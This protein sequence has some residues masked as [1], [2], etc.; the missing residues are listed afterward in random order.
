MVQLNFLS[1]NV[2]FNNVVGKIEDVAQKVGGVVGGGTGGS[3]DKQQ[4]QRERKKGGGATHL[5]NIFAVPLDA[6]KH[7][8]IIGASSNETKT[9]KHTDNETQ[10][11]TDHLKDHYLFESLQPHEMKT[12]IS[13]FELYEIPS[14]T[15][16]SSSGDKDFV[17]IE[18]GESVTDETAYFYLIYEGNCYYEVNNEVVG[19]VAKPGDCFGELALLYNCPRAATVKA[20]TT[21]TDGTAVKL[22]RIHQTSF[23]RIL[24]NEN[25]SPDK[26]K[27]HLLEELQLVRT[28]LSKKQIQQLAASM[29][30]KKFAE[31]EM[32]ASK[33]TILQELTIIERGQVRIM[34]IETGTLNQSGAT[35]DYQD[36]ILSDG[37]CYGERVLESG[38][39]LMYDI[40]AETDGLA[41]TIDK[42]TFLAAFR[43]A[44]TTTTGSSKTKTVG[45]MTAYE[46]AVMHS[47]DA[48]KL[49]GIK[50]LNETIPGNKTRV[51]SFLASQIINEEYPINWEIC[52]EGRTITIP[53]FYFVR[54]GKVRVT[55]KKAG[56]DDIIE[57]DFY[58]GDDQ[59]MFDTK[60][61][62]VAS[63]TATIV[64]E[65]TILGILK[66]ESLRKIMNTKKMGSST[67]VDDSSVVFLFDSLKV[68]PTSSK[69]LSLNDLDRLT[70]LGSGTFGQVWLVT[71][72]GTDGT[73]HSYALKI[74]SK[75]ELIKNGQATGVIHE[76][77][78]MKQLNH[79]FVG[80]LVASFHDDAYV[81]MLMPLI[82]GGELYIVMHAHK[83]HIMHEKHALFY[84]AAITEGLTYMH[85]R[86][87][88]YR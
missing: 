84:I 54:K 32:L 29:K 61:D 64:E 9:Y 86:G 24:Q 75:Y 14:S 33:G 8:V 53:A 11:L 82:Q 51:L 5:R 78:I 67:N 4:Q 20:V 19:E 80:G 26:N 3:I 2:L 73:K 81:Y 1:P 38:I 7:N 17:L 39:P 56:L 66:L 85:R 43:H 48:K 21:N 27:I 88:V 41:F 18:Q 70:I 42:E 77:E 46:K 55:S 74:Q 12:L 62:L 15:G 60:P 72:T 23:R 57:T 49:K 37:E 76:K 63:Y 47:V 69:S 35:G 44:T 68:S 22:F 79:P 52:H 58:F 6:I 65:G 34:N 25:E 40:I 10:F 50:I 13:A 83:N 31:G 87:F 16:S 28:V 36:I 59:L 45:A 30:P 71:R